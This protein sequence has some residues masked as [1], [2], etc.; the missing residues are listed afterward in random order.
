LGLDGA[1]W[2]QL[3]GAARRPF[4]LAMLL[5]AA[6]GLLLA[7]GLVLGWL[8]FRQ[9]MFLAR[10][11]TEFVANVSHELKTPLALIRLFGETRLFD[12]VK[13]PSKAKEY[14]GIITR[15]SE[16]L[17]HL[18]NNILDF[19]SLSAGRKSFDL[20]PC[21]LGRLVEDTFAAYRFQL[22]ERGFRSGLRVAADL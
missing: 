13:E 12:R 6:L 11:K 17:T 18:V 3:L 15:E 22:E 5:E 4:R 8:A 19:S 1:S 16:R 21:A 20:K 9:E 2:D 14:F 7:L 10:M